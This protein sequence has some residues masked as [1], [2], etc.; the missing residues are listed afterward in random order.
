MSEQPQFNFCV[1]FPP[2][3]LL[4]FQSAL[5]A[6]RVRR[7]RKPFCIIHHHPTISGGLIFSCFSQRYGFF[8]RVQPRISLIDV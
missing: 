3:I 2:K 4:E 5:S 7:V 1:Y 6:L 8:P